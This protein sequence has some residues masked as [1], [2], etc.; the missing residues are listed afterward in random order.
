MII[1]HKM[2]KVKREVLWFFLWENTGAFHFLGE[3]SSLRMEE[4]CDKMEPNDQIKI[5][6]S[7]SW[8]K[9]R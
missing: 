9:G 3:F 2:E 1:M 4:P 7:L 8:Q 6:R 5:A